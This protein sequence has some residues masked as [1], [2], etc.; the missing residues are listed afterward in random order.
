MGSEQKRKSRFFNCSLT[1]IKKD[2]IT[3]IRK[4]GNK[5]KVYE[6]TVKTPIKE[7]LSLGH[8][9]LTLH[10]AFLKITQMQHP[11]KVLFR[12]RFLFRMN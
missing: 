6:K 7:E 11:I 8:E 5:I 4:H 2:P 3:L 10:D 1:A 12:L 9:R